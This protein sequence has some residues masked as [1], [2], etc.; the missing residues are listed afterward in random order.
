VL[1]IEP[2]QDDPPEPAATHVLA[3]DWG[4]TMASLSIGHPAALGD[5][6][7]TASGQFILETPTTSGI[8]GDYDQGI[9]WLD[10]AGGPGP[11]LVLPALPAGWMYEGWVV[12]M[13]G[14]ISTGR[15]LA[16]SGADS[17]AGGPDSGPDPA[18]PFPGQDFIDPPMSLVGL[19]AVISVEPEPDDTPAPFAIK[20]LVDMSIEDVGAAVLQGMANNSA[21]APTGTAALY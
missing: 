8:P 2:A 20:P 21:S 1:T 10:P 12:N 3:G 11:A 18:P 14:P 17:D 9:W 4:G 16:P 15:F 19:V 13:D 6:F 7:S 5:D